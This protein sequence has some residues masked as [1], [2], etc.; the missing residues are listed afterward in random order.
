MD[1]VLEQQQWLHEE[2]ERVEDALM[3]ERMLKKSNVSSEV[4]GCKLRSLCQECLCIYC[5]LQD[6]CQQQYE[7][8]SCLWS[9]I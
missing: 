2:R 6:G 3:K 1:T 5:G 9:L 4:C 7:M 8:G